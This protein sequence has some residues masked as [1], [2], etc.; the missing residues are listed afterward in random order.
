MVCVLRVSFELLFYH[1]FHFDRDLL[2]LV[3]NKHLDL[4]EA[5]TKGDPFGHILCGE[6]IKIRIEALYVFEEYL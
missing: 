2:H 5:V 4:E 1:F 6:L 3:I